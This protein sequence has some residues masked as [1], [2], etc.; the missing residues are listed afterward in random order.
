MVQNK[1][2]VC[3]FNLSPELQVSNN[4]L[5]QYANPAFTGVGNTENHPKNTN[6]L[7][8]EIKNQSLHLKY[9]YHNVIVF[10]T[11]ISSH[12]HHA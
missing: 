7:A 9:Q 4:S 5:I 8:V 6:V 10:N 12:L 11:G 2:N 3:E 1:T